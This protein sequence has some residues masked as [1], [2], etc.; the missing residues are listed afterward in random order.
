MIF[1]APHFHTSVGA[2]G[3]YVVC[4]DMW[5]TNA[6]TLLQ[7][8]TPT[9]FASA[10]WADCAI[11]T[12][13]QTLPGAVPTNIHLITLDDATPDSVYA[14]ALY[15]KLGMDPAPDDTY[16]NAAGYADIRGGVLARWTSGADLIGALTRDEYQQA[17]G[18]PYLGPNGGIAVLAGD[19]FRVYDADGSILTSL[20]LSPSGGPYNKRGGP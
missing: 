11:D 17:A 9:P 3:V 7:G 10:V 12:P 13:F 6:G 14:C 20:P 18:A 15:Q 1:V 4:V 8:T 2:T 5:G 16:L 19:V